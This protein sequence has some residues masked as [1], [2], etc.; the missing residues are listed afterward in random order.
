MSRAPH[1]QPIINITELDSDTMKFTLESTSLS[2]ANALRR[3][4]IAEVPTI[5]ID[6]IQFDRNSS[7][8]PDEFIAHRIGLIPLWSEKYVDKMIDTRECDCTEG[9]MKCAVEFNLDCRA[10]TDSTFQVTTKHLISNIPDVTPAAGPE[11]NKQRELHLGNVNSLGSKAWGM[12]EFEKTEDE[13]LICKLR[14]GQHIKF[15]AIAK[16]G[17]GKEH[18]KWIP[19]IIGFE[20][21]PDNALRHTIYPKPEEWPKS[22]YSNLDE[23]QH[24][25]DF[26][27]KGEPDKFYFTVEPIGQLK[28][29]TIM[30][31]SIKILKKKLANILTAHNTETTDQ[32]QY[33]DTEMLTIPHQ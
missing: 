33:P 6:W 2:M 25:A 28:P 12:S 10:E 15:K 26:E 27:I 13:I 21:D 19:A 29:E 23:D 14:K 31:N 3:I 16:R 20:Y 32:P 8:L 5:A 22:A 4:M 11:F 17:F 1:N 24:Q 7:V 18:A 30:M 9:C